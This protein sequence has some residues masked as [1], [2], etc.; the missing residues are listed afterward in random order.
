MKIS[1]L[2]KYEPKDF[3]GLVTE[4]NLGAIFATEPEVVSPFI[5]M[6]Y[7]VFLEDDYM[8]LLSK[9]PTEY[10]SGNTSTYEWFLQGA[11]EKNIPLIGAYSNTTLTPVASTAKTGIAGS[12]FYLAFPEDYFAVTDVIVGPHTDIYQA[13][14]KAKTIQGGNVLYE[15]ELLNADD[16]FVPY[17]D[18]TANAKWSKSFSPVEETLSRK[19]GETHH[20]SP[21]KMQNQLSMI[22]K[23]YVVPGNMIIKGAN[24]PLAFQWKDQKGNIQTT[25][26]GKLEWDFMVQFR[27][28]VAK[29]LLF[30]QSNKK[31]DGTF[32]NYGESGYEIKLGAGLRQQIAPSNLHYYNNFSID[33]L[34]EVALSLSVNKLPEDSRKFV[35]G[36]GEYGMSIFDKAIQ[37]KVVQFVPNQVSNRVTGSGD[38]MGYQGQF[39]RIRTING[40]EFEVY[41]IGSYDD[42]VHNKITHPDGGL[43]ES[44]RMTLMDFGTSNGQANISKVAIKGSEELYSYIQGMRSP[45]S[46]NNNQTKPGMSSSPID[47]YEVHRSYQGGLKVCNP[48]RMAELIPSVLL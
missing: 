48:M 33:Y 12:R 30:G 21:F 34:T 38:N 6:L 42:Q 46:P 7:N 39:K 28:E 2:Q 14:I 18:L 40:I 17:A 9:F 16:V 8:N 32:G 19:G 22:R 1:A 47:G 43:A 41:K 45:F 3:N 26:I 20:T 35:I 25:W 44:R 36:T 23:Q 29:L 27:R 15:C 24:K 31:A 4:N 10:L 11:D 13:Q 37:D 5:N